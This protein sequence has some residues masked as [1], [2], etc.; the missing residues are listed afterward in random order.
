[1]AG[2]KAGAIVGPRLGS[3]LL[4]RFHVALTGSMVTNI[5]AATPAISSIDHRDQSILR[6]SNQSVVSWR[7]HTQSWCSSFSD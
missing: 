5:N 6:D 7:L 3:A 1:M 2:L 4:N